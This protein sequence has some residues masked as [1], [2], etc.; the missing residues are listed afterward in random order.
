MSETHPKATVRAMAKENRRPQPGVGEGA[1]QLKICTRGS[2]LFVE[3]LNSDA[4]FQLFTV[5]TKVLIPT[6]SDAYMIFVIFSPQTKFCV[7]TESV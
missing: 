6:I 2:F 5:E 7:H 4:T 3:Q 1:G